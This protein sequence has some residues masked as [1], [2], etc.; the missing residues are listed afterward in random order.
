MDKIIYDP[1]IIIYYDQDTHILV[2]SSA[3]I[4]IDHEMMRCEEIIAIPP[5]HSTFSTFLLEYIVCSCYVQKNTE[6]F[7]KN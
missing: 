6:I 1:L 5:H 4:V 2:W 3:I 7:L